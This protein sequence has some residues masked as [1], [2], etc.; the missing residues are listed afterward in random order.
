M[1]RGSSSRSRMLRP[2]RP[3]GGVRSASRVLAGQRRKCPR[4]TSGGSGQARRRAP[5]T[6]LPIPE[7]SPS[8]ASLREPKIRAPWGQLARLK[9]REKLATAPD[10][11]SRKLHCSR[12]SPS[13]AVAVALILASAA[14]L[15]TGST[16]MLLH[17]PEASPERP[18]AFLK[19]CGLAQGFCPRLVRAPRHLLLRARLSTSDKSHAVK[20]PPKAW[21]APP[22][23]A[24]TT[25][26]APR[27]EV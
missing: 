15:L 25:G 8:A 16:P 5:A 11:R 9:K 17:L 26:Q 13:L 6:H 18:H 23:A 1:R 21:I 2:L 12:C 14:A 7:I 27:L 22:H 19:K 24:G 4:V 10:V 3:V 20:Y